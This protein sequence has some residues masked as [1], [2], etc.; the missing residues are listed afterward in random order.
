MTFDDFDDDQDDTDEPPIPGNSEARRRQLRRLRQERRRKMQYEQ[1]VA[2]SQTPPA[3]PSLDALIAELTRIS[4]GTGVMPSMATFD[5]ARPGN[6]AT[7]DKQM[8]RLHLTWAA[9]ARVAGLKERQYAK[10]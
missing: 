6:W 8:E 2:A 5:V 1:V 9:L 7:A 3:Q 10:R 4:L